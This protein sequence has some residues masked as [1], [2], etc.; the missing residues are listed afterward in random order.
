MV[1]VS[2][3]VLAL[4]QSQNGKLRISGKVRNEFLI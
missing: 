2:V 4:F 3:I 1:M